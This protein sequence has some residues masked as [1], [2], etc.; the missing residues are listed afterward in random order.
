M[1]QYEFSHARS[2][3]WRSASKKIKKTVDTFKLEHYPCFC[4]HRNSRT[5]LDQDRFNLNVKT[6]IC[7]ECGQVRIDPKPTELEL[8]RFYRDLYRD[9]Y[10]NMQKP[11]DELI[12]NEQ[13]PRGLKILKIL[14]KN[15]IEVHNK[16]VLEIGAGAAGILDMFYERGAVTTALEPSSEYCRYM[17]RYSP[18]EVIEGF[19]TKKNKETIIQK[20]YDVIIISHVLEHIHQPVEFLNAAKFLLKKDGVIFIEVPS[21]EKMGELA[22]KFLD[23]FHIAHLWTFNKYTLQYCCD[24]AELEPVHI[25]DYIHGIFRQSRNKSKRFNEPKV[26]TLRLMILKDIFS[27]FYVLGLKR[28][29]KN[30]IAKIVPVKIKNK[31][32][33]VLNT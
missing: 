26:R 14:N 22:D 8:D 13:K 33:H 15:G 24:L 17:E 12:L 5:M 30:L 4:G 32:K 7:L 9:L 20:R 18:H 25:D 28:K 19:L 23:F 11:T 3:K 31:I 27:R 29:S 6:V 2:S 16:N 21:M 10:F 1:L